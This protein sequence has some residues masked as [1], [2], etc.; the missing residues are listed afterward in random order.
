LIAIATAGAFLRR[1]LRVATSYRLPYVLDLLTM[2]FGLALFFY[3]GELVGDSA[4]P[5]LQSGY[6]AFAAIGLAFLRILQSGVVSFANSLREEQTT[7][8]FEALMA[9][10]A[11]PS[12]IILSSATYDLLRGAVSAL[13]LIGL[14]VA[15]FD[16]SLSVSPASAGIAVLAFMA[17]VVLLAALGVAIAAFTVVFKQTTAVLGLAITGVAL[18]GGA[19][20]PVE[21]MPG[22]LEAVAQ[23]LPF[24]WGLDVLRAALLER[25][26]QWGLFA[27]LIAA[28]AVAIPVS[29]ALFGAALRRARFTGTLAHY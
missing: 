9:S 21:V 12:L 3:I 17:C 15:I 4:T 8:T 25:E 6:F 2:L 5:G 28:A 11:S 19:Y 18:L 27:A 10:P 23:A 20:F 29:L 7:G 26:V 22:V 16:L 13:L 1:D 24:T 14:G